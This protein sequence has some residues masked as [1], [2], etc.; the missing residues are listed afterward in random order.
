[1]Q[2]DVLTAIILPLSLF[3]IMFGMGLSLKPVDFKRIFKNPKAVSIGFLAQLLLLP[4]LAFTI[5][6]LLKLPAEIAVGLMIIALAPGGATSN[7][8]SYLAKGD[9]ALSISL[10]ALVSIITPF[11]IPI[12]AAFSISYFMGAS[13]SFELPILKTI[14][15]L[16]VITIVPVCLGMI[17]ASFWPKLARI[18]EHKLK[19]LAIIFMFL[20]ITL[21]I[22]KNRDNMLH[23]FYQAG[24]ATLMLNVLALFIG[25]QL[26][27]LANLSA[28]QAITI[29]FEVGIQNGTLAL[30]VAGT[31]IGNATMMIPAVTY[32][33]LMFITGGIFSFWLKRKNQQQLV[34][35][36]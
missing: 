8:F 27:K 16:L 4:L 3:F 10:T 6:I 28:K 34:T 19:W 26:A 35:P 21:I 23:F 22:I 14:V 5:A 18:I 25:F 24:N 9:V 13:T 7:M 29:S 1:M 17:F 36:A 11:S 2:T 32:G 31:L 12:I 33:L 30:V 15:Q 20:I